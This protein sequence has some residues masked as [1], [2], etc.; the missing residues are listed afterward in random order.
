MK[1]SFLLFLLFL[2]SIF[3]ALFFS[4][5]TLF[6][7]VIFTL[8]LL[9]LAYIF[10]YSSLWMSLGMAALIITILGAYSHVNNSLIFF[11]FLLYG[12]VYLFQRKTL[13]PPLLQKVGC[14][15][16]CLSLFV[17]FLRRDFLF[18]QSTY[19][20]WGMFFLWLCFAF[21]L[22][23]FVWWFLEEMGARFEEKYFS[24]KYSNGQL[25]L[26]TVQQLKHS[27]KASSLKFQRRVRR[28]FGLKDSG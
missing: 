27:R 24:S 9:V 13:R 16:V 5:Q 12:A 6:G 8:P 14:V 7:N 15:C 19:G 17:I 1:N 18:T 10:Y 3:I 2:I 22:C 25:N 28:R 4:N 11:V 20:F 23:V 26:F 21:V